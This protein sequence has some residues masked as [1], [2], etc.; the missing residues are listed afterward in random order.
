MRINDFIEFDEIFNE[1]ISEQI[2]AIEEYK[3]SDDLYKELNYFLERKK[4]FDLD[5][6]ECELTT[7]S[8]YFTF[9]HC[10]SQANESDNTSEYEV[11]NIKYDRVFNEF[12][13]CE[14]E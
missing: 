5:L 3:Y 6:Y 13:S 8:I 7:D 10:C 12:I 9:S 14:Y 11:F 2:G 4:E 1:L